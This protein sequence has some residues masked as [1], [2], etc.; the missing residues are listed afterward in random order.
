MGSITSNHRE[1]P[2]S[3]KK[4]DVSR[5]TTFA[6]P[7]PSGTLVCTRRTGKHSGDILQQLNPAV[8]GSAGN[9]IEGNIGITISP[10]YEFESLLA[11]QAF[12]AV[13]VNSLK[14]VL[15]LASILKEHQNFPVLFVSLHLSS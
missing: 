1:S 9:H 6:A 15:E 4:G 11:S 7:K 12:T 8:E 2:K 10:C 3:N 5:Y 14:G 13:N